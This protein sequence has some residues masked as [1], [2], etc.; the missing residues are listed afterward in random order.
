MDLQRPPRSASEIA[1]IPAIES[2]AATSHIYRHGEVFEPETLVYILR[3][4]ILVSDTSLFNHCGQLLVGHHDSEGRWS[5]RHCEPIIMS[6]AVS[7]GLHHDESTLRDFRSEVHSEIWRAIHAGRETKHFWEERFG[8]ALK[9]KCIEIARK[10]SRRMRSEAADAELDTERTGEGLSAT[11]D[12]NSVEAHVF[13]SINEAVLI[14]AIQAL[15]QRQM[16]AAYLVW[17]EH[18]PVEGDEESAARILS[19]T[20]RAVYKLLAKARETLRNDRAIR[21]ML[22]DR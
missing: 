9:S 5:G 17:I 2:P 8:M 10:L 19:V 21:T 20:P 18:R 16:R 11:L 6:V 22:E 13:S 12:S 1:A 14:K 3:E 15:P 4:L 7:F